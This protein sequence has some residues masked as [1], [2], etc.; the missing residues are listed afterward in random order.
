MNYFLSL[1]YFRNIENA[2][3]EL[4]W[5]YVQ[6]YSMDA[7]PWVLMRFP[8]SHK[9]NDGA[10]RLSLS[11]SREPRLFQTNLPQ[12]CHVAHCSARGSKVRSFVHRRDKDTTT[13]PFVDSS[14]SA[15]QCIL[16]ACAMWPTLEYA[17]LSSGLVGSPPRGKG[18]TATNPPP[19]PG[20]FTGLR[21]A[22]VFRLQYQPLRRMG[23]YL[24]KS[25]RTTSSE[26]INA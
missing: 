16:E 22:K 17:H 9:R 12:Y 3:M 25:D 2:R 5:C 20:D 8:F 6:K 11:H 14:P 1:E 4:W 13:I 24:W 18:E 15:T 19:V 26:V 21:T 7:F 10:S 23:H